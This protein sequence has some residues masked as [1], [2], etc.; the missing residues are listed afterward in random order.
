MK[1]GFSGLGRMGGNMV[2]RLLENGQEVV[3]LNRSPEPVEQAVVLGAE[4]A[5]DY[6]DLINKLDPVI[7]W[8]MLPEDV[9]DEHFNKVLP[10][11]PKGSILIDGGNSNF[12][13]S[14]KRAKI[15]AEHGVNFMDV[16]TSGGI[17]GRTAGYAMMVGG[18][19]NSAKKLAPIFDSLAPKNGWGRFGPAG[20]GHYVK[21]VHNAIEYG[22]MESLVEGYRLI[23]ESSF[24]GIDLAKVAGVWQQGSIVE[25]LLNRMALQ[26][27][28]KNPALGG[29]EGV[30]AESGEARWGL[31]T[32][33]ELGIP[34]PS[35][36]AAFDVRL[37]SQ[38]GEVTYATRLLAAM[39]NE[40]GGHALNPTDPNRS[41][42]EKG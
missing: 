16:G 31:E 37:A 5:Q 2:A 21:M 14:V 12:N 7:V 22:M 33:K 39:R 11:M 20:S 32:A 23:K 40:F 42:A 29:I 38:K 6:K 35:I 3:V 41:E 24:P 26:A 18:D 27:L 25:S 4:A 13:N 1:I 28:T 9:T 17:L 36:Q 8:L 19:E 10:L 15:A 30:V 34:M